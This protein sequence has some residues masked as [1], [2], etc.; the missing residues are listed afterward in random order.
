MYTVTVTDANGCTKSTNR[1]LTVN[2]NPTPNITGV[3]AICQGTSTTLNAGGGYASYAW[4]GGLGASQ[5]VSVSTAGNYTVTVTNGFN[6]TGTDTHTLTVN[7]LPNPNIT[8]DNSICSGFNTTFDAG[9]GFNNYQ[10][11]NGLN[12]QTI[13]VVNAN[14]YTVTVTDANLCTNTDNVTLTVNPNPVPVITGNNII[15]QGQNTSFSAATGLPGYTYLWSTLQTSAVINVNTAGPYTVTIT[16]PNGCTG[17]AVRNLTVNNNPVPVI[18]GVNEFCQGQN[19]NLNAGGGYTSYLWTGGSATQIINVTAGGTYMVTVTAPNGCTGIDTEVVTVNPLPNPVITGSLDFCQGFN[20]TLDAGNGYTNYAWST[21]AS[22]QTVTVNNALNI[23][24]TVTDNNGCI[25][26]TSVTTIVNPNPVPNITGT[27]TTCQ[28]STTT[29]DAG[30]GYTY[31][32][33][34]GQVTQTINVGNAGP[35]TVTVTDP[36]GCVGTDVTNITVFALP[37]ATLSGIDTICAGES[38][39]IQVNFSGPGPYTYSYFDGVANQGPFTTGAAVANILVTP[40]TTTNYSL[41]SVNNNN[42]T[43]TV[44]GTANIRVTP[45]PTAQILGTTDIC[46][47]SSTN[48][49]VNFTGVAPYTY[50]YTVGATVFGPFTTSN[51]PETINVT[52]SN[53]TTYGLTATVTG[54]GCVGATNPATAIVTV[55]DLPSAIITG[56][57]TI[58]DG[59]ATDLTFSFVGA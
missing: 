28:G 37:S 18:T 41:V 5:N 10:W 55:N 22:T 59:T 9:A 56:D 25:D 35:V 42:C 34:T 43:G 58:C 24:V 30:P 46:D 20:T 14:T 50:S 44:S 54:A 21:G 12:T 23:T 16:D 45:L 51:D 11:S 15:C 39:N 19:Q 48:L 47:G 40:G 3:T 17:I 6:C 13:T 4:S 36:N 7:P 2:P 8:G 33:S 57:N 1:F 29:I 26:D 52:P 53:T 32:W 49:S 27:M 31:F 38:T